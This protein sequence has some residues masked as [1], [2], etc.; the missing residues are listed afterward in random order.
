[1]TITH[2]CEATKTSSVHVVRG[3]GIP[4]CP[5]PMR[6][7]ECEQQPSDHRERGRRKWSA[8]ETAPRSETAATGAS[9]RLNER[10]R[11]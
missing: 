5:V 8:V 10:P 6:R 1:M 11:A 7:R 4:G 3:R 9:A 2:D